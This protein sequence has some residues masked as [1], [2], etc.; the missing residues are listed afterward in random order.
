[1]RMMD[2]SHSKCKKGMMC[3]IR[4]GTLNVGT[5]KGKSRDIVDMMHR[6]KVDILCVQETR[7]KGGQAKVLAEGYKLYNSNADEGSRNGVGII[8]EREL[9]GEVD[10]INDRIMNVKLTLEGDP[11]TVFSVYAPQAG[12]PKEK[13]DEFWKTLERVTNAIPDTER[14]IIGGD[15][16][17][18]VGKRRSGEDG[19]HGGW[20]Y[21][22]RNPEGDR[23]VKF[24]KAFDLTIANT[25]FERTSEQLVT[26]TSGRRK[27]QLDYLLCRRKHLKEIINTEVL[28]SENVAAQHKLVV[29]DYEMVVGN[30]LKYDKLEE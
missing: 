12:C 15:L 1:M 9:D 21:G 26:Y 25:N 28:Y 20:S 7:W 11:I 3:K 8:V 4:I 29:A 18:H 5:M 24:A 2:T 23:I 14:L 30:R 22:E 27:S 13:K 17:G 19:V 16:N 6:R 10:R